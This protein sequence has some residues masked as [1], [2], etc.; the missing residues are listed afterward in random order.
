VSY[1]LEGQ[2]LEVCDCRVLCPC[3]IGEDPDNG[4]CDAIVAYHFNKGS[5]DGIDVAGATLAMVAHIPEN[6]VKGNW[7][8]AVYIDERASPEQEAALLKVYT[9]QAGGPVA[10]LAKLV[11]EVVAVERAAIRFDV[12]EGRGVVA[13]GD[14]QYAEIEPYRGATGAVTTL[15]D[16]IFSNVPGSPA[17]VSKAPRYRSRQP[18][19]GIDL[20]LKDHNAVEASFVFDA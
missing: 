8:V 6:V 2:L 12:R 10:D 5:I 4:T 3:W 16:T 15:S 19:L 13:I 7:R 18:A 11:G 1:H 14:A 17:F 20:D 9:G